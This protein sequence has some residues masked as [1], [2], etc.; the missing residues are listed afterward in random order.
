MIFIIFSVLDVLMSLKWTFVQ[1]QL[2]YR[3]LTIT[4]YIINDI[5]NA[6]NVNHTDDIKLQITQKEDITSHGENSKFYN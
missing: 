1:A 3:L 5:I 2:Q 6:D 4:S